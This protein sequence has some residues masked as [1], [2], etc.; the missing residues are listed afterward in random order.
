MKP[1]II[2]I[3]GGTGSGKTFLSKKIKKIYNTKALLIEQDAYYK[4]L[5]SISYKSRIN[6]N[7]DHPQS[8]D[9]KLLQ[10]HLEKLINK[11]QIKIPLYDFS[12]HLRMKK[13]KSI[14]QKQIIIIEGILL[15]HYPQLR[16]L[17]TLK[18]FVDT[19]E[20]TRF[21]RRLK[22]D[23]TERGRTKE[24]VKKQYYDTVKPMHDKFVEPSKHH[25]DI[26]VKGAD[27][28]DESMGLIKSKINSI[29]Q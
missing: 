12:K 22:R 1:L 4:D 15:L 14:S 3:A 13:T 8:I 26:I 29:L 20:S 10:R 21:S 11:K 5:S 18:I 16:K 25:A 24:S 27:K 28:T 17:Y 9:V 19:P 2:A 7:F 23:I 6:Q